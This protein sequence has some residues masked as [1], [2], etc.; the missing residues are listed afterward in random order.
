MSE[1][2]PELWKNR[3]VI[4]RGWLMPRLRPIAE[5]TPLEPK[6]PAPRAGSEMNSYPDKCSDDL[7]RFFPHRR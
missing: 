4:G 7:T 1:P 5:I 2:K 3:G 6:P